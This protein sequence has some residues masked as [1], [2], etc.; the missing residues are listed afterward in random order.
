MST[1]RKKLRLELD[2]LRVE[3]F[4]T[5]DGGAAS[6]GTVHGR[7]DIVTQ[8]NNDMSCPCTLEE[9]SCSGDHVCLCTMQ[10]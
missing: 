9:N 1:S 8:C 5:V 4:A 2:E 7:S 3:A 10:C 6:R